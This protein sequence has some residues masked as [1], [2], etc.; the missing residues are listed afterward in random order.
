MRSHVDSVVT[1]GT[2]V[3]GG[4]DVVLSVEGV[5]VVMVAGWG[6]EVLPLGP[7][8]ADVTGGSVNAY[9]RE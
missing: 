9:W 3:T 8:V 6:V 7:E 1:G 2:V 5:E 4:K